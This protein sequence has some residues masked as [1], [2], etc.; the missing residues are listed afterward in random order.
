MINTFCK[1][2]LWEVSGTLAA[3]AGGSVPAD[4][5]LTHTRLINVCTHEI[6]EDVSVAVSCGR[7]ALVGDASHCILSLI[8]I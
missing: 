8:H 1:R 7:I 4:L 3:V 2:P 5:V 6:M